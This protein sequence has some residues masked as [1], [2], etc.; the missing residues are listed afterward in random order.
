[1]IATGDNTF[2]TEGKLSFE[3]VDFNNSFKHFSNTKEV[4]FDRV[5]FTVDELH[6]KDLKMKDTHITF[7]SLN[8]EEGG[9]I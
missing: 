9:K 1:M 4:F 5:A 2:N 8:Q 3:N 7:T 6:I